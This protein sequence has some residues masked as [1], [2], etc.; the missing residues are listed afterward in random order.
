M[1]AISKPMQDLPKPE[2]KEVWDNEIFKKWF[3]QDLS[4]VHQ[5]RQP[6]KLLRNLLYKYVEVLKRI[7]FRSSETGIFNEKWFCCYAIKQML[8]A[9]G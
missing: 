9:S 7:H 2:F 8:F 3:V 4:N 1:F 6:G 5:I